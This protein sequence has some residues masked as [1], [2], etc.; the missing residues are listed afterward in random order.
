M[1]QKGALR[2]S[3]ERLLLLEWSINPQYGLRMDGSRNAAGQVRET[4]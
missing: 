4:R 1:K 2:F 3:R